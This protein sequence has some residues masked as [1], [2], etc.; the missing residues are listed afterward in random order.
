M[1]T[2]K[3]ITGSSG[4]CFASFLFGFKLFCL[5]RIVGFMN[6][7]CCFLVPEFV[8]SST[9][10]TCTLKLMS[11]LCL[12]Y[13]VKTSGKLCHNQVSRKHVLALHVLALL[14]FCLL[15][16][17]NLRS[18]KRNLTLLRIC[19]FL[20]CLS[21]LQTRIRLC[22]IMLFFWR[23]FFDFIVVVRS[24]SSSFANFKH[25]LFKFL[26]LQTTTLSR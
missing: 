22:P 18:R 6:V 15:W 19:I 20:Q 2:W 9:M 4:F 12:K 10:L 25:V 17:E 23:L 16:F 13:F 14:A 5:P 1:K 8:S 7:C 3:G 21:W 26:R 11:Q 24:I